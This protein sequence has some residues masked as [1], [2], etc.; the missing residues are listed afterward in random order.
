MRRPP[1]ISTI[2][3]VAG[4]AI[5]GTVVGVSAAASPP[6][7]IATPVYAKP[8]ATVRATA[9]RRP[10]GTLARG[11]S[12]SDKELVSNR[13]Y[14]SAQDGFALASIG[15]AQYPAATTDG[16]SSWKTS[17]PALHVNAVQAPLSVTEVG[18]VS[19][20]TYYYYGGG[21]VVDITNDGGRHW[22]RAVL[23]ELVLGVEHGGYNEIVG[24]AQ[25]QIDQLSQQAFTW[26]YAT[27]DGGRVW[28]YVNDIGAVY[29]P[30][31]LRADRG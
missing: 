28:H 17:G 6:A 13:V 5:G 29:V 19:T 11:A 16:G 30:R 8:K 24:V 21:Q 1:G 14:V 18:A 12:V 7:H 31:R 10:H 27:N 20:N 4:I 25:Q 9:I 15:Q 3:I 22:W 23:G 26:T 2:A